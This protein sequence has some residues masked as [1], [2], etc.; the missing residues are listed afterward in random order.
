MEDRFE[1]TARL[2]RADQV[3]LRKFSSLYCKVY[4]QAASYSPKCAWPWKR[5]RAGKHWG[6]ADIRYRHNEGI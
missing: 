6:R 3:R 1:N 4:Q 2:P 5:G